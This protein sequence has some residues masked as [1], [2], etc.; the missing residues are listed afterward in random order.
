MTHT[1]SH[2]FETKGIRPRFSIGQIFKLKGTPPSL[3]LTILIS[4]VIQNLSKGHCSFLIPLIQENS[5]SF[6]L[7]NCLQRIWPY[8]LKVKGKSVYKSLM[9]LIPLK[10]K[11][12]VLFCNLGLVKHVYP[13]KQCFLKILIYT[14]DWIHLKKKVFSKRFRKIHLFIL[15][16][17]RYT[18][19][20]TSQGTQQQQQ[21]QQQKH[22]WVVCENIKSFPT[23]HFWVVANT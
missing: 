3:P 15:E 4:K 23:Y 1:R 18:T 22:F 7:F 19:E 2:V 10:W 11:R 6:H 5:Q 16:K 14:T 9:T 12:T 8:K 21:Q 13:R 17:L 20:I